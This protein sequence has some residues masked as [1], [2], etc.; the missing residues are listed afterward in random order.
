MLPLY[1]FAAVT[2]LLSLL[3]ASDANRA[4][5]DTAAED[6]DIPTQPFL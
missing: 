3:I 2:I 5:E 6:S 1:W 4:S